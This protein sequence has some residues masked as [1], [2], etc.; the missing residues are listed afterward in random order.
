MMF[1]HGGGFVF[2]SSQPNV[3][4]P[5]FFM[6]HDVVLVTINYRL[7][8]LGFLCLKTRE[9]PGNAGLKDQV[10]ALKWIKKN[11]AAFNGDPDNVTIFGESAGGASVS[12]HLISPMSKGLFHKAILHSGSSIAPWAYKENSHNNS[13]AV[14][15]AKQMGYF[16]DDPN[17]LYKIFK[18]ISY[19]ELIREEFPISTNTKNSFFNTLRPFRPCIEDDLDGIEAFITK[20]PYDILKKGNYNKVPTIIGYNSHE[21]YYFTA[22]E[23][24]DVYNDFSRNLPPD[25]V[26]PTDVERK[27]TVDIVKKFYFRSNNELK[28]NLT[29]IVLYNTDPFFKFPTIV[30]AELL[31]LTSHLPVFIYE[32]PYNGF[33]NI[34]KA[35]SGFATWPGAC[36]ADE[37]FYLFKPRIIDNPLIF[38]E[39]KMVNQITTMWTNFAKFR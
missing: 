4:G 35:I 3:Y 27:T 31:L 32:F 22:K 33:L 16:T 1:I 14:I 28:N 2:G 19:Y 17:K 11:I 24:I 18:N 9:A 12:Y 7:D 25:L 36:H 30:E 38:L 26:F 20:H 15:F 13:D 23:D 8:I 6:K 29:P 39:Q 5:D 10:A 34:I 37:L 21:G